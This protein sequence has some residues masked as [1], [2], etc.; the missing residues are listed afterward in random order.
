MAAV[1][2]KFGRKHTGAKAAEGIEK[3]TH[4]GDRE[5]PEEATNFRSMAARAN[6]LA[7]GRPAISFATNGVVSLLRQP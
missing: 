1:S 7:L 3:A 5:S 6:D 2:T 4:S